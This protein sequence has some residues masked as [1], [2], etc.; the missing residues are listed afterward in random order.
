MRVAGTKVEKVAGQEGLFKVTASFIN[1]GRLPTALE[2]AK[3]IHIVQEDFAEISVPEG[4]G[5][6]DAEGQP[7]RRGGFGGR[8]GRGGMGMM[9]RMEQPQGAP[10]AV[11]SNRVEMGWLDGSLE[12]D[13]QPARRVTWYVKV[14]GSPRIR[15]L[16][17]TGGSTRGGVHR[18]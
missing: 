7:L 1:E 13:Y 8:G 10:P 5:L 11:R 3:T 15:T 6:V 4:M 14:E 18:V 17:V 9:G 16:T 12:L 2:I